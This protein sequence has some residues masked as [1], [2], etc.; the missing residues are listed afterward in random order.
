MFPMT[1]ELRGNDSG[2]TFP[3]IGH[4]WVNDESKQNMSVHGFEE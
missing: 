2:G 1:V 3:L 4:F